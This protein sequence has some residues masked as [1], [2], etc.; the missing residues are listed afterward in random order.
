MN[1]YFGMMLVGKN[2]AAAALKIPY[3][4]IF[5]LCYS[6]NMIQNAVDAVKITHITFKFGNMIFEIINNRFR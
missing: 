3:A 4:R 5:P 1:I 6:A 2:F